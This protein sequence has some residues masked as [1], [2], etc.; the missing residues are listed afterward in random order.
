MVELILY[1]ICQSDQETVSHKLVNLLIHPNSSDYLF[2]SN[3]FMQTLE[4]S[5]VDR[6]NILNNTPALRYVEQYL[7]IKSAVIDGEMRYTLKQVA[8]YFDVDEKTI[9]RYLEEYGHEL[10]QNGYEVFTGERLIEA[11]KVYVRDI[12]VPELD[13]RIPSLW[14]FTFRAFLNIGMLLTESEKAK[15]LRSVL[16]NIVMDYINQRWWWTTKYINQ[17]DKSFAWTYKD[18]L[19]YRKKFTGALWKYVEAGPNKYP[20]FTNLVY[21]SIFME[22]AKE[23]ALLLKLEKNENLRHTLYTE[24]LSV[25]SAFENG[26]AHE[27]EK[28][29]K[30]GFFEAKELFNEFKQS[31]LLEPIMKTAR[32]LMASRDKWLRDIL[33]EKMES[34]IQTLSSH[35]L[36]RF[37]LDNSEFIWEKTQEFVAI[38]DA[39]KSVL[40]RLKDR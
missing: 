18:S 15:Q 22:H 19:F 2:I 36:Q 26:F 17:N 20:Y 29:W 32:V 25:V 28:K 38:L 31:P 12:N 37:C 11:K 1:F 8:E 3:S 40:Q 24:I 13:S 27:L 33:H 39:N 34:Y 35:E 7:D 16:L 4:N 30:C 5:T 9:K 21:E 23:Y 14:L 6:Q 10:K